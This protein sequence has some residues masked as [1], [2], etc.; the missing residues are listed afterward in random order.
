MKVVYTKLKELRVFGIKICEW[1][2]RYVQRSKDDD[3]EYND[4]DDDFFIDLNS[5]IVGD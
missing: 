3:D 5:R 2:E 1:T 4:D